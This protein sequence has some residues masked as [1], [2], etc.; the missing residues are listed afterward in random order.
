MEIGVETQVEKIF[1][2][3]PREEREAIIS[4][5]AVLRLSNLRKRLFLAQ[6]K[7]RFFEE[8]YGTSLTQLDAEGLPESAG[9]EMHEDYI[10]W[11]HWAEVVEK[12]KEDIVSLEKIAERGLYLG[13]LSHA[14]Y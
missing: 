10:M 5:G 14:G 9:Y 7:V 1:L 3:L 4:H 13:E 8:Q 12:L 2:A 6:S 11:H